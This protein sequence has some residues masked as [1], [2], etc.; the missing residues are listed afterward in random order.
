MRVRIFQ[1]HTDN[2]VCLMLQ[3]MQENQSVN[4]VM[5]EV[6]EELDEEECRTSDVDLPSLNWLQSLNIMSVPSLPT[7]PSSPNTNGSATFQS[8]NNHNGSNLKKSN[9]PLR[10]TLSKSWFQINL[11]FSAW[12]RALVWYKTFRLSSIYLSVF[13]TLFR[14]ISEQILFMIKTLNSYTAV[15][16]ILFALFHTRSM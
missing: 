11:N 8:K 2:K 5:S 15:Q 9:H 10:L 16:A 3:V 1:I 7:P 12:P 4:L 14:S 13:S 6:V